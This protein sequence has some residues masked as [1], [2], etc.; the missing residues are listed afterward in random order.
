MSKNL[1]TSQEAWLIHRGTIEKIKGRAVPR[2]NETDSVNGGSVLFKGL[3]Q[4][5]SEPSNAW[6]P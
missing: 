2:E 5:F 3:M 1:K 6:T 4:S